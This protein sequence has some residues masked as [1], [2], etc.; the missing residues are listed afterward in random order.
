[1]IAD[2]IAD[3]LERRAEAA[4]QPSSRVAAALINLALTDHTAKRN[5]T[6][7]RSPTAISARPTRPSWLEPHDPAERRIW[8]GELWL[9]VLSAPIRSA[10]QQAPR[11]AGGRA[12]L[13]RARG[14][15]GYLRAPQP[16][17]TTAGT[18]STASTTSSSG[19]PGRIARPPNSTNCSALVRPAFLPATTGGSRQSGICCVLSVRSRAR[20]RVGRSAG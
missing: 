13:L 14:D 19:V 18:L 10:H 8:R 16:R 7:A 11:D 2:D 15:Q 9:A 17:A 3:E 12:R 4:G 6:T 5:I 20:S 1:M